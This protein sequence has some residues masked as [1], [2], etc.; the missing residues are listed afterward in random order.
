MKTLMM[1]IAVLLAGASLS[2]GCSKAQGLEAR[3]ARP[4]K[5]QTI[6]PAP[7]HAGVR[8]SATIEPFDQVPLAFRASGYIADLLQR[9]GSDGRLRAVQPGDPVKRGTVLARVHDADYRERV[10]QERARL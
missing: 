6:A 10:N 4:V 2:V 7:P 5:A 1:V 3:P 9:S 8:Y